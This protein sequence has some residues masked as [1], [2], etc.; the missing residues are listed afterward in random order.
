VAEAIKQFDADFGEIVK[1]M[2]RLNEDDKS[3]ILAEICEESG[4]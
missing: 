4:L 2:L 1:T 3:I